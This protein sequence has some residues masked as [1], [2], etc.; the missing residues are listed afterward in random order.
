[1]KALHFNTRVSQSACR[2]IYSPERSRQKCKKLLSSAALAKLQA[3][4]ALALLSI[5][6]IS[7][8]ANAEHGIEHTP[9]GPVIELSP[10]V[11]QAIDSGVSLTFVCE[12]A[13]ISRWVLMNWPT[14]YKTHRFV[15][16]KH[17]LADRYLVH[18]DDR[19]T[20]LIFR[21]SS[22]GV[23][24]I[25]KSAQNLFSAYVQEKPEL[26]LRVSLSKYE[27][28]APIRLTAFTSN[29]W[30]FNSGWGAWQVAN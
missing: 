28:P 18:R 11:L 8:T 30:N 15:I 2:K 19:A 22:Q 20:P 1:M 29:Q 3:I 24:Y 14:H 16:S 17:A 13:T 21:S 12:Y 6:L 9:D 4:Y 7:T 23:A 5:A 25:S 26:E 27:L 10:S